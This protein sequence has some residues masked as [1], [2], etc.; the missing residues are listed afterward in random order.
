M[1]L[2]EQITN[3]EAQLAQLNDE[4]AQ[5]QNQANEYNALQQKL[6]E[7]V[8]VF[9]RRFS[10]LLVLRTKCEGAIEAFRQLH[11]ENV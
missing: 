5:A 7:E 9:N 4:I 6:N 1:N 10:E 8:P 2:A 3:K 11:N